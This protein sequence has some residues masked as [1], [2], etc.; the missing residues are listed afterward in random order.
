MVLAENGIS[1]VLAGYWNPSIFQPN[2]LARE[3]FDFPAN[4]EMK[5]QMEVPNRPGYPMRF[6]IQDITI[7]P[8][9]NRITLYSN[10]LD[11][12]ILKKMEA[13]AIN[14]VSKLKYTPF[15]A[16]G[17]NFTF[18]EEGPPTSISNNFDYKDD[19]I[20]MIEESP[21]LVSRGHVTSMKY[22]NGVLNFSRSLR[23]SKLAFKF[24]FHHESDTCDAAKLALNDSIIRSKNFATKIIK[25]YGLSINGD[26]NV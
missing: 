14:I 5:V 20:N 23:E 3:V 4:E 8:D 19:P 16:L 15:S 11:E 25:A 17:I 10:S 9:K 2:W 12:D 6:T 26:D 1:I 22:N 24:N 7:E 18:F 13:C 21:E